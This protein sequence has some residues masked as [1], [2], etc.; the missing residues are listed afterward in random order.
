MTRIELQKL[1][2]RKFFVAKWTVFIGLM[3]LNQTL[4]AEYLIARWTNLG[5]KDWVIAHITR[6]SQFVFKHMENGS[7]VL[8]RFIKAFHDF[9]F[10]RLY[11]VDKYLAKAYKM[12]IINL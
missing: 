7:G 3:V 11:L 1:T 12:M 9:D 5:M 8:L 4:I 6:K 2:E 10:Y